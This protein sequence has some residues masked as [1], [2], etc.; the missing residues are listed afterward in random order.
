MSISANDFVKSVMKFSI[1]SW[2]NFLIGI[3]AV[4]V[5]TRC[6][7]PDIY[8]TINLF[9]N[10][11]NVLI[12]ISCLGLD[13]AFIRFYYEP[14]QGYSAEDVFIKCLLLSIASLVIVGMVSTL[15]FYKEISNELFNRSSMFLVVLLFVNALSLVILNNFFSQYYRIS[16]NPY[17][18]TI[19]QILTQFFSKLFVI[20]AAI[21]NPSIEMV[22]FINTLGVFCLMIIYTFVKKNTIIKKTSNK[23]WRGFCLVVKFGIYNWP[24]GMALPINMFFI[25]FLITTQLDSYS[26]GIYASAGF[27]VAAFNVIQGG[28]RTYW[29]AFMYGHYSDEQ[30]KIIKVHN[31]IALSIIAL[32]GVFI[33]LQHILYLMIGPEYQA[34]RMFFSLV[35]LD[36]LLALYEQT[37]EYGTSLSKKNWQ[38]T[39][40]YVLGVGINLILAYKLLPIFGLLGVAVAAGISS[41]IRFVLATWRGQCYYRSIESRMKTIAG[42]SI[43]IVLACSNCVFSANYLVELCVIMLSFAVA[44]IVYRRDIMVCYKEVL[45][46]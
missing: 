42:L 10:A 14:P 20:V 28:F 8:G 26:L 39:I 23:D 6:F 15:F 38:S 2:V 34:S 3:V 13:G 41:A 25:P 22:L 24:L 21:M 11:T 44:G 17:G 45:K 40:I 18:Y 29:S 31:F 35:L 37:T 7:S 5:M 43:I 32:L 4:V 27:F 1:S 36:P 46:K 33:L 30:D 9:N 16:N 12:G 19:Q